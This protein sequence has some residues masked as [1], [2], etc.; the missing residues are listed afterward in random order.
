MGSD[1]RAVE[2]KEAYVY[3]IKKMMQMALEKC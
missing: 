3:A 2:M 1:K